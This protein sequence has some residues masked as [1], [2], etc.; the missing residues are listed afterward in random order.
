MRR[1]CA[2]LVAARLLVK[3]GI[4]WT[5]PPETPEET[6]ARRKRTR[7]SERQERRKTW[8]GILDEVFREGPRLDR[9]ARSKLAKVLGMLAFAHDAEVLVAARQ[10]ERL[11]RELG[12]TWKELLAT[13]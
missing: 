9:A 11:R 10:A 6:K 13:S 4:G 7:T 8:S 12:V 3:V 2:S 1:A 5:L